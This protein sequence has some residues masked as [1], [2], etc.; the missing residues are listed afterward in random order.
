MTKE[1]QS[2]NHEKTASRIFVIRISSFKQF[3]SIRVYSWLKTP[4]G[5]IE[6]L[7]LRIEQSAIPAQKQIAKKHPANCAEREIRSKWQLCRP[8]ALACDER[9]QT[10]NRTEKRPGKKTKQ[11]RAPSQKRAN[12]GQ[13]FQV[14]ASHR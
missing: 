7:A 4:Y 12:R 10:D 5:A 2:P 1:A 8:H 9:N 6:V 13:K 14:A 11:H 3:V